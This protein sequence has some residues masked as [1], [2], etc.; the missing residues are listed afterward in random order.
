[1]KLINNIFSFHVAKIIILSNKIDT[2]TMPSNSKDIPKKGYKKSK[3][4]VN[5]WKKAWISSPGPV[6]LSEYIYLFLK[7]VAMGTADII[8]GVSGGT[9]AL[10]TGIY[11]SLLQAISSINLHVFLKAL[12]F[13]FKGALHETHLRFLLTLFLGVLIAVISTSHFTFYLITEYPVH[14]WSFLFGLITAAIL[15][16]CK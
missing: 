4:E 11:K 7:G 5:S 6:S 13:N 9:I 14:T 1:M 10:I 16:L 3:V 2:Q 12:K 15:I 8:P